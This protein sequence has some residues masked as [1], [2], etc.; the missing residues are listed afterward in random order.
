M[1]LMMEIQFLLAVHFNFLVVF[2]PPQLSALFLTWLSTVPQLYLLDLRIFPKNKNLNR[3]GDRKGLLEV[4]VKG[5]CLM[6]KYDSREAF[7][8]ARDIIYPTRRCTIVNKFIVIVWNKLWLPCSSPFFMFD[9]WLFHNNDDCLGYKL[10][11]MMHFMPMKLYKRHD[12]S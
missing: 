7:C 4:T 11:A 5:S 10:A 12:I 9:V 3:E 6:E 1:R 2:L 8:F